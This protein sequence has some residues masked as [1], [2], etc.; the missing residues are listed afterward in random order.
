MGHLSTRLF[1]YP[2]CRSYF[3]PIRWCA[4]DP[5]SQHVVEPSGTAPESRSVLK[6]KEL[7]ASVVVLLIPF[8][9]AS[10]TKKTLV[11]TTGELIPVLCSSRT[12]QAI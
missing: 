1:I 3:D 7:R 10:T 9:F 11:C 4:G 6:S 8:G 5:I 2:P 12:I